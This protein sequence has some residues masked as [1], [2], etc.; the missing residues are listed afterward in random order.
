[1]D[2]MSIQL[3]YMPHYP[4]ARAWQAMPL[5]CSLRHS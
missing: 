4:E 5:Q 3:E 1:M 2:H